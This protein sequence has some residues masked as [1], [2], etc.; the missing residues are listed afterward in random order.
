MNLFWLPS[1]ALCIAHSLVAMRILTFAMRLSAQ[2]KA[3]RERAVL[4]KFMRETQ[5]RKLLFSHERF[6]AW[7]AQGHEMMAALGLQP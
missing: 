6:V 2:E 1:R 7:T 4:L 3:L 5:V